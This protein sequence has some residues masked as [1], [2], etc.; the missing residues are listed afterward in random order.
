VDVPLPFI[1]R[2]IVLKIPQG[3]ADREKAPRSMR[4][5]KDIA[6]RV[7]KIAGETRH[8]FSATVFYLLNW[9]CD[10]YERQLEENAKAKA[11]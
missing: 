8:D 5:P 10:E 7:E 9:A 4:W 1:W 11:G 6:G 3:F 2:Y